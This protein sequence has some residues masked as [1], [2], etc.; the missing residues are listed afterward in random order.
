[1]K[2]SI[3][4]NYIYNS[5]YQVLHLITP[6]LVVPHISRVL[7]PDGVGTVSYAESIVSYFTLFATMGITIY[8]Q[9][10]ISYVQ[11]DVEMRSVVFWNTKILGAFSCIVVL[12]IYIFFAFLHQKYSTIYLFLTMNIFS[13]FF[14]VSWFFQG[15]EEFGKIVAR[16]V[17]ARCMQVVYFL[18]FVRTRDDILIYVL[19]LGLFTLL[20]NISLWSYLPRYIHFVPIKKIHP[21]K[22]IKI[23]WSLFV[24]TIAIQIYTVLDKTMIGLIT[25]DTSEN[26]YY[27]QAIKISKMLLEIVIALRTVMIPRIGYFFS[28]NDMGEIK[29]LM[30]QS[31]RFVWFLGIPLCFGCIITAE[32]FVPWFFGD[33]YEKV[34]L[35]LKI[36]PLLILAIG[37]NAVTGNQYLIPTKQQ[38]LYTT[39]VAVGAVINFI[40]NMV[41]INPLQSV[42]A[43]VASV[44]AESAIAVIQILFVRR[45]LSPW[46]VLQ[47]SGHYFV[48][49]VGMTFI[50]WF[51]GKS[52]SPSLFHTIMLITI[53]AMVYFGILLLE[54]DRFFLSNTKKIFRIM[55]R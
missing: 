52:L 1:M 14:D 8:G 25:G 17:I 31:Y 45:E 6:L 44:I 27:E 54:Q 28:K 51:V 32:N 42:G 35:L 18:V 33:G 5:I 24:P 26:G 10:E 50:I 30:Y 4:R 39:T 55:G 20:G 53:G 7:G 21:F 47:E 13:V 41:L 49:G 15:L 37:I 40:L 19:G 34:I 11:N 9:R 46:R 16:N 38:H 29:K 12:S 23:V 48:A 2:K 3:R 36:L 43:A 22:D